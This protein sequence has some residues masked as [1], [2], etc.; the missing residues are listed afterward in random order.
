VHLCRTYDWPV[1]GEHGNSMVRSPDTEK[2]SG[3]EQ[4]ELDSLAALSGVSAVWLV[5]SANF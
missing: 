2:E 5:L 3:G 1:P 4:Q